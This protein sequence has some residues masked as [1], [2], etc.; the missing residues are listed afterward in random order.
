MQDNHSVTML[1]QRY[2]AGDD[3]ALESLLDRYYSSVQALASRK[4]EQ[5]LRRIVDGDQ[6]ANGVF[7]RLSI[8]MRDPTSS[9]IQDRC[10]LW[11]LLRR[12][13]TSEVNDFRKSEYAEKRDGRRKRGDSLFDLGLDGRD[14]PA[15][16]DDIAYVTDSPSAMAQSMECLDVVYDSLPSDEFREVFERIILLHSNKEIMADLKMKPYRLSRIRKLIE[17]RIATTQRD[18]D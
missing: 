17:T 13:V 12:I 4:I 7:H 3:S 11:R 10:H 15:G 9:D 6:I 18:T 5:R 8:R 14:N 2:R 1:L 16:L